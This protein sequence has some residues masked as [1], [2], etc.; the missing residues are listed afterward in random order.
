MAFLDKVKELAVSAAQTT[1]EKIEVAKVSVDIKTEENK[2]R[3]VLE[4]IGEKVYEEYEKGMITDEEILGLCKEI[5]VIMET[6]DD[7]KEKSLNLRDKKTCI[8]CGKELAEEDSFCSGCGAKQPEEV[9][10][11]VVAEEVF[12]DVIVEEMD[13]LDTEET[14]DWACEDTN[15]EE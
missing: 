3:K 9:V 8:S 1:S 7:L 6:I 11:E 15:E 2:A 14:V 10:E 13:D 4:K 12:D 5:D